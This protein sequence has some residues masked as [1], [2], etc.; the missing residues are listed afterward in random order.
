MCVCCTIA[1][2]V[3]EEYTGGTVGRGS[4]YAGAYVVL[5]QHSKVDA[6]I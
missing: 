1:G 6:E 4:E 2:G 3:W 5:A